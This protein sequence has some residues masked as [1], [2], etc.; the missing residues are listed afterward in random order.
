MAEYSIFHSTYCRVILI[1]SE[2]S[3]CLIKTIAMVVVSGVPDSPQ[4]SFA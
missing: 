4:T 1:K 2:E 3:H